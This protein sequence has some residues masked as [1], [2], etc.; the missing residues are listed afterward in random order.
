MANVTKIT[1]KE[2]NEKNRCLCCW[3]SFRSAKV[4]AEIAADGPRGVVL[5]RI[6]ACI[7]NLMYDLGHDMETLDLYC[8]TLECSTPPGLSV[9]EGEVEPEG[10]DDFRLKGTF[11]PL[12]ADEW[13]CVQENVSPWEVGSSLNEKLDKSEASQEPEPEASKI[14]D[15]ALADGLEDSYGF[16]D[17][18]IRTAKD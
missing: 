5:Y 6:G 18:G 3:V 8:D 13:S 17:A 9:W 4:S 11:R 7:E 2:W 15:A 10:E 12:T 14:W 1:E 16:G